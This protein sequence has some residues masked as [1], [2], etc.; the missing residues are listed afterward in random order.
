MKI[1]QTSKILGYFSAYFLWIVVLLTAI[2]FGLLSQNTFQMLAALFYI[3]EKFMREMLVRFLDRTYFVILG[4]IWLIL[5]IVVEEY[6]RNSVK[7]GIYVLFYRF[8]LVFGIELI[9]IFV[10]DFTLWALQGW[11]LSGFRII[12]LTIELLLGAGFLLSRRYLP[13]PKKSRSS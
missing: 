4:L 1:N 3:D 13:I 2:L 5:M 6:F 7:K 10:F 8:A 12:L 9:L 11:N